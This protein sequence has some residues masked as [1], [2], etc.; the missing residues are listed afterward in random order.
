MNSVIAV[1]V[2]IK[3]GLYKIKVKEQGFTLIAICGYCEKELHPESLKRCC[4]SKY[5]FC[6]E[7]CMDQYV[8]YYYDPDGDN[9]NI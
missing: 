3:F 7:D 8:K 4:E 1:P 6:S 5:L 2:S 9:E